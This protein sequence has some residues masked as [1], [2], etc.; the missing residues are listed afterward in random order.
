MEKTLYMKEE[1]LNMAFKMLDLDGNGKISKDELKTVLGSDETYQGKE[2]SFWD[3][4]IA[5]VDKN[6]D[7]EID[8]HEF[9]EMMKNISLKKI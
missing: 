4:M 1:K 6:G 7:G 3:E 8:Y 9:I 5:E 2:D